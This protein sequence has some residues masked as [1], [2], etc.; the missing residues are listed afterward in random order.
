MEMTSLDLYGNAFAQCFTLNQDYRLPRE[1]R[2]DACLAYVHTGKQEIFAPTQKLIA[3]DNEAILMK[4]G[5]YIA[6]F[7]D[8]SHTSPFKSV[9]F[10]LDPESIKKA[11]GDTDLSFLKVDKGNVGM[12]P[13]L[14]IDQSTLMDNFMNSMVVYF[15]N[16][17]LATEEL[18]AV[19]LQELVYILSDSGKNVL[20]TQ[21]IGTLYTPEEIAF[22]DI[23]QA[24]LY[25]SLN[26]S[27]LAHLAA[28]S[29]S[30]FKRDFKKFYDESPA[31]YFRQRRLEKA[32]DLLIKSDL[33]IK[34]IAWDCGFENSAHFSDSF[35]KF[36][37]NSP[38]DYKM[39]Q[40]QKSLA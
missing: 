23:V 10:H 20:A 22:D 7:T 34:E 36:F 40:K 26:I 27:E 32:A 38:R 25:N 31:K 1:M 11:F 17:K 5:N 14:K 12:N 19:K 18:L 3:N 29:E 33:Q 8:V 24:N 30:T 4:C 6:N 16:P 35:H 37:G 39:T 13:A 21:I 2:D 9:V 28:R 15:N